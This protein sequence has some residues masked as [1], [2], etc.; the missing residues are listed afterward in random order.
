MT[1]DTSFTSIEEIPRHV[2]SNPYSLSEEQLARRHR[3]I[4][5]AAKD[6]PN[7]PE[8]YIEQAWS[9]IETHSQDKLDVMLKAKKKDRIIGQGAMTIEDKVDDALAKLDIKKD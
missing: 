7:V 6:Y 5:A 8:F 3:D 1:E 9:L 4:K 2:P